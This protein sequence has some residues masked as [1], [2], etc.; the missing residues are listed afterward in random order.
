MTYP[1]VNSLYFW[2]DKLPPTQLNSTGWGQLTHAQQREILGTLA[3]AE[4]PRLV[5]VEAMMQGWDSAAY[6]PIRPLERGSL[7]KLWLAL[8]ALAA[9]A[10]ALAWYGTRP[11]VGQTTPSEL[12]NKF[13][14]TGGVR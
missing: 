1:G 7:L 13:N 5:V 11:R 9:V 10:F 6:E 12:K 3:K 2:A 8:L 14:P 4:R